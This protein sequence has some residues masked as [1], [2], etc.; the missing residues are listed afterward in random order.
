MD[1]NGHTVW[2]VCLYLIV[3]Q[4]KY[5]LIGLFVVGVTGFLVGHGG[6]MVTMIGGETVGG[7]GGVGVVVRTATVVSGSGVAVVVVVGGDVG[8]VVSGC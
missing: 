4:I 6:L 2:E 5:Q 8:D 1:G 3:N 7:Q